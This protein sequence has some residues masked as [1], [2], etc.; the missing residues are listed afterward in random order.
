MN[1]ASFT[2]IRHFP[3]LADRKVSLVSFSILVFF[4]TILSLIETG[5]YYGKINN[6]F[7]IP[8]VLKL[9]DLPQFGDDAFYQS[10]RYYSSLLWPLLATFTT[11][12]TAPT[13]FLFVFIVSRFI[14]FIALLWLAFEFGARTIGTLGLA[15][16]FLVATHFLKGVSPVG[17]HDLFID[18]LSH[19]TLATALL[20]L[21]MLT[22]FRGYWLLSCA[23]AGI[24]F[25][26]NAILGIWALSI[27]IAIQFAGPSGILRK[28]ITL[29]S[30]AGLAL[31]ALAFLSRLSHKNFTCLSIDS[32]VETESA[33]FSMAA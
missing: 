21:S 20:L 22:Q 27:I 8:I 32:R 31:G 13:V 5:F 4:L 14:L 9:Y 10:L 28:K 6:T 17:A 29:Y 24:A 11:E 16:L 3:S 33:K 15:G 7:H 26:T 1:K 19:T 23:L 2:D 18:Y 12:A 30:L 25:S